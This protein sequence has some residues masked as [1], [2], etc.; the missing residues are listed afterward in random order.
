MSYSDIMSGL[1][2]L[3]LF[4]LIAI[5]S[6]APENHSYEIADNYEFMKDDLYK[7]LYK[8][9]KYDWTYNK[10]CKSCTAKK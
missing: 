6:E 2:L 5:I 7:E 10:K 3:F 9:F 8:E 4:L 1:M